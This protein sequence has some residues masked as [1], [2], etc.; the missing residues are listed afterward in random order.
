MSDLRWT[1]LKLR[2]KSQ[3]VVAAGVDNA[4]LVS[5]FKEAR[6]RLRR[7]IVHCQEE[8]VMRRIYIGVPQASV[9]GP[10]LWNLVY[11]GLLKALDAFKD[12]NAVAFADDLALIITIW[13]M[14]EIGDRIHGL[15][16]AVANWS[17]D[18]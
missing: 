9:M 3:R 15:V 6:K 16:E 11:N 18:V 13:K 7:A 8:E 10:L 12:V 17:N 1:T 14:H 2:R 5:E 4:G